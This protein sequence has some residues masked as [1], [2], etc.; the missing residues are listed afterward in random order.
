MLSRS[1]Y[2]SGTCPKVQVQIR[3]VDDGR[4]VREEKGADGGTKRQQA[5]ERRDSERA[6]VQTEIAGRRGVERER[7]RTEVGEET[8]AARPH[9]LPLPLPQ[10]QPLARLK[11]T[12]L[13]SLYSG[14]CER[15][16][17]L[18]RAST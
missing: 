13:Y 6:V 11:S 8:N 5:H 1:T 7:E 3:N 9:A 4:H 16:S 10:P 18:R 12:L 15:A 2:L 17:A 14:E